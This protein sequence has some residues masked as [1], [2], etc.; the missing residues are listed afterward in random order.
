MAS[1]YPNSAKLSAI[2]QQIGL[3]RSGLVADCIFPLVKTDCLF[4]YI[5]WSA[6]INAARLVDDYLGCKTRVHEVDSEPYVLT[7]KKLSDWG[8]SQ[9]LSECCV[10]ICGDDQSGKI[11]IGKTRQLTNKLLVAREKRAVT[12]ATTVTNYTDMSTALPS[13]GGVDGGRFLL[14]AA[15][16][17]D[18][19]YA[20]LAYFQ[21]VQTG[22]ARGI[23]KNIA[24]MDQATLNGLLSHPNFIGAG[25]Q[26]VP[27]TTQQQVANLLGVDKIC[28]ADAAY[29]DSLGATP[30]LGKF[31]PAGFI[32]FTSSYEFVTSAD[33]TLAFGITAYNRGL[34]QKTWIDPEI[35]PGEGAL[36]QK[37]THD[38]T[39]IVLS[40]LAGT[41]VKIGS[42]W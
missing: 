17:A 21:G 27:L 24:V 2:V 29:N 38:M 4:S 16:F 22:S 13:A 32:L 30:N 11:E 25:Y 23:K 36:M 15:N 9:V 19:N 28:L 7:S 31:W 34:Q 18:P 10:S 33:E 14:S 35:G 26:P 6:D 12:L 40:Y 41:L 5:D 3:K 1:Q 20:L 42:A 8:L 37:I 39:E